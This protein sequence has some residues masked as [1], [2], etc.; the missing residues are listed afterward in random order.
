[1]DVVEYA[2]ALKVSPR[3]VRALIARKQIPAHRLG[4]RWVI[5]E[6]EVRQPRSSRPLS[7]ASQNSLARALHNRSLVGLAGHDRARTAARIR[8][9][10]AS[11]DPASLLVAWWAGQEPVGVNGGTNLVQHALRGNGSYVKERIQAR[12]S[13]YLREW[14]ALAEVVSSERTIRGLSRSELAA[15]S[16]VTTAAI[17]SIEREVPIDSISAIRRVLAA[18]DIQPSAIPSVRVT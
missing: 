17:S 8:A 7:D 14:W 11:D 4:G 16:N 15:L 6:S 12:P 13:E 18:L 3:R 10:R 5:E 1:M 9:L 2:T